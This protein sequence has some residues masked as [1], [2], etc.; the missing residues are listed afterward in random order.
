[1][2][3]ERRRRVRWLAALICAPGLAF[4]QAPVP[5]AQP[6]APASP[7]APALTRAPTLERF[8]EASYP[9]EAEAQKVEGR[10]VLSIDISATGEVTRAEV[11]EPAGHGFDEAALAAAFL[12]AA[13]GLC[14]GCELYLLTR[15]A[16]ARAS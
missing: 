6:Q 13:F 14:L 2:T 12:N 5:E 16:T 10:V 3:A 8:V 4:A 9:P 1:M 7:A 15:R 11:V